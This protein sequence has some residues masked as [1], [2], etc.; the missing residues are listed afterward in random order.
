MS[1]NKLIPAYLLAYQV[2]LGF[3]IWRMSFR[4]IDLEEVDFYDRLEMNAQDDSR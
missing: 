4:T 3:I 1:V 2:S